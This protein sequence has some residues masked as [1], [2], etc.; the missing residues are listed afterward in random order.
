[1]THSTTRRRAGWLATGLV[2]GTTI[3][4]PAAVMAAGPGGGDNLPNSGH[5]S[6]T[7]GVVPTMVA[8]ATLSC[9]ASNSVLGLAGHFTLSG[10]AA[11]GTSVVIYLTPNNGSDATPADNVENNEVTVDISGLSGDVAFSLPI[12]SAFTTTKGGILA[13]FAM[14]VDGSI[15]T[16]KSNSLNCG[17]A[18]PTPT[19]TEVPTPTPTP[20]E[21]PTPTPTEAPTPTPTEAPTPTPTQAPTPTPTEAPT[22]TPTLAPTPTPTIQPEPTPTPVATPTV[23]PVTPVPHVTP[24]PTDTAGPT[25]ESTT[26]SSGLVLLA[27]GALSLGTALLTPARRRARR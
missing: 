8:N 10:T 16:S 23:V 15:Y 20:T 27:L 13:V 9:D 17:E 22:P 25:S 12:S 4:A 11:A 18:T 14:D 7:G 3:L 6:N 2:A 21:A 19:P 5:T 24:P 26:S 1:M